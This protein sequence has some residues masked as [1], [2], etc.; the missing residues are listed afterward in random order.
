MLDASDV[1]GYIEDAKSTLEHAACGGDDE[2]P[3]MNELLI[4]LRRIVKELE[5]IVPE[6]VKWQAKYEQ[7]QQAEW[8]AAADA[9]SY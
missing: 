5:A 3:A 8:E 6:E 1:I 7:E 4:G 9:K 2:W